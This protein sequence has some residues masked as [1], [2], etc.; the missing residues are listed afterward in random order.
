[1]TSLASLLDV[2][3]SLGLGAVF[4]AAAVPKLHKPERFVLTVLRYDVLPQRIAVYV[5][6]VVPVTELIVGL[7]LITGAAGRTGAV[8]ATVLAGGFSIGVGA[9]LLRGRDI[10]CGCFGAGGRP[11]SRSTLLLDAVMIVGAAALLVTA[12]GWATPEDWSPL[13]YVPWQHATAGLFGVA[14]LVVAVREWLGRLLRNA[15]GRRSNDS[16][17]RRRQSVRKGGVSE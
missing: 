7:F 2:V 10:D 8:A 4:L 11:L 9:N 1:M 6:R 16:A 14:S 17:P 13:R 12:R 5:A 3:L 15:G